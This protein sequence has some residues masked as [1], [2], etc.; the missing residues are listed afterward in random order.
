MVILIHKN[1]IL[2][3]LKRNF[4]WPSMQ[5]WQWPIYNGTL[6]ALSHQV[7]IRHKCFYLF[8]LF[9]F[10]LE[11]LCESELHISSLK[12][13]IEKLTEINTFRFRKKLYLPHFWSYQGCKGTVVNRALPCLH[14]ESLEI[15]LTVPLIPVRI[16]VYSTLYLPIT[17]FYFLLLC[18]LYN[19][20][21]R[22][23][24]LTFLLCTLV[25]NH[26]SPYPPRYLIKLN[27]EWSWTQTYNIS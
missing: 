8:K 19:L 6:E 11:L 26:N 15:T 23:Y 24:V 3:E 18:F 16:S 27:P 25:S 7:L 1:L 21:Y 5:R 13:A 2:K 10:H 22:R 12:E 14:G 17:S 4:K 9:Y 20:P